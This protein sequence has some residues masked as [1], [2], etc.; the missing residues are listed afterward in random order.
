[1][2]DADYGWQDFLAGGDGSGSSSTDGVEK[3]GL[4][5]AM[6]E[7][8]K[9]DCEEKNRQMLLSAVNMREARVKLDAVMQ[10]VIN[11]SASD[12]IKVG[13]IHFIKSRLMMF[14]IIHSVFVTRG[15]ILVYLQ[16]IYFVTFLYYEL[17]QES[18]PTT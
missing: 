17:P 3:S 10:S 9:V 11:K 14:S 18:L 13:G 16:N 15:S 2:T 12:V 8:D 4:R 6:S 1:M 7:A 5:G